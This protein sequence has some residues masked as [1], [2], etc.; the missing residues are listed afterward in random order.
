MEN[1]DVIQVSSSTKWKALIAAMLGWTLDA[2]DWMMLALALPMIGAEFAIPLTSQGLLGTAT[3]LGAIFGGVI[4]GMM[5][6]RFGRVHVLMISMVFYALFTGACGLCQNYTQLLIVRFLVG[7]GLGGEWGVGASLV[8]EYWPAHLRARATSLVHSGW[9]IGYGLAAVAFMFLVPLYGWR[10][11]FYLGII[12]AFVAIWVR[13]SVP[14]PQQFLKMREAKKAAAAAGKSSGQSSLGL[15][16]TPKYIRRTIF[17]M[18]MA[19][20][21]LMGYWGTATWLPSFM[22][23]QRGLDIIHTGTY[24]IVLNVGAWFGYQFYGWLADKF[25]RRA[26]FKFGFISSILITLVYVN[27]EDPTMMLWVGPIFGF[28]TYGYYGPSGAFFSELYP[29]EAR[30]TG[31]S[32]L[33]NAGR[34]FSMASPYIIGAVATA[35]GFVW[36]L[37]TTAIFYIIAL[38]GVICLPETRQEGNEEALE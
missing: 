12:P 18:M 17:G 37:G 19:G 14:E 26:N 7:L 36:G 3:L 16:F 35:Y 31:A 9:P 2:G 5:A 38:I 33:F 24:L 23:K 25:G 21:M 4:V 20:G 11:L 34:G 10:C 1:S 28:C 6:D 32:V 8:S 27:I 15:M 13:L 29:A 30:A 22:M